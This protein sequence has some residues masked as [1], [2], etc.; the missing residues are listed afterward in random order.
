MRTP[1]WASARAASRL[2]ASQASSWK[3]FRKPGPAISTLA[4][5]GCAGSAACS[6]TAKSRGFIA[7]GLANIRAM[8]LA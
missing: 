3:K 1:R 8:L 2:P 5:C 7:A 4:T 6:L